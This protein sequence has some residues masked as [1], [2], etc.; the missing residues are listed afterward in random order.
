MKKSCFL[1]VLAFCITIHSVGVVHKQNVA[2]IAWADGLKQYLAAK[3]CSITSC[4]LWKESL[5]GKNTY[6]VCDS[7]SLFARKCQK[8]VA[9]RHFLGFLAFGAAFFSYGLC[10]WLNNFLNKIPSS[11]D[12]D[13]TNGICVGLGLWVLLW[14]MPK[15][16]RRYRNAATYLYNRTLTARGRVLP[17]D[18]DLFPYH[19]QLAQEW[20]DIQHNTLEKENDRAALLVQ[21]EVTSQITLGSNSL[22]D[23]D[24]E[25]ESEVSEID[26]KLLRAAEEGIEYQNR[27]F[28]IRM[29]ELQKITQLQVTLDKLT[30]QAHAGLQAAA[31]GAQENLVALSE[32]IPML[33]GLQHQSEQVDK[34]ADDLEQARPALVAKAVEIIGEEAQ[35]I[36][37]NSGSQN[38]SA[39]A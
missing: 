15:E 31:D 26:K 3:G 19:T 22:N 28:A 7:Q 27:S 35:R 21:N 37:R 4:R 18:R 32:T 16:Y 11:L 5:G 29:E 17:K 38:N 34:M 12:N 6:F 2:R 13:I 14:H 25:D 39:R 23:E 33:E 10:N 36:S 1:F 9:M 8:S 20:Y 24:E 30:V